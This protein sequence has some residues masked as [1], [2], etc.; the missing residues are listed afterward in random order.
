M[1]TKKVVLVGYGDI[2]HRI[3]PFF[4]EKAQQVYA[5]ARQKK[6]VVSPLI[7]LTG[8]IADAATLRQMQEITADLV[9]V[10]L[11]PDGRRVEDYQNAFFNNMKSLLAYWTNTNTKPKQIIFVSSS[12][13]YDQEDG[14]WVTE[15]TPADASRPTA[16]VL[17]DTEN[18][19]RD[20]QIPTCIVR[21]SG[22]YGPARQYLVRQVNEGVGGTPAFTNR[23]HIDDCQGVLEFLGAKALEE[24]A[25]PDV[26]LASDC[27]PVSSEH[28][29]QW[30]S[31]TMGYGRDHLRAQD[32]PADL[33]MNKRCD[34]SLL[35]SMGYQFKYPSYRQGYLEQ[36]KRGL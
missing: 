18:L 15:M 25:L 4:N 27:E 22:I 5:I 6:E 1:K 32:Q 33:K 13:V 11:S 23:I 3:A 21:F 17:I 8:S 26:I 36:I 28:I 2:A 7:L 35:L 16:K 31:Q 34:N 9:I 10:T 24:E 14:Q 19:L 29:R 20:S 30:M 12:S